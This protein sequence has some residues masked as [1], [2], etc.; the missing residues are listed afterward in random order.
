ML[1]KGGACGGSQGRPIDVLQVHERRHLLDHGGVCIVLEVQVLGQHSAR[2]EPLAHWGAVAEWGSVEPTEVGALLV[3]SAI[4]CAQNKLRTE[5]SF[6]PQAGLGSWSPGAPLTNVAHPGSGP[7]T[8]SMEKAVGLPELHSGGSP[9][10][11]RPAALLPFVTPLTH[12]SIREPPGGG[13]GY[14]WSSEAHSATGRQG[15][16]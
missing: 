14:T 13:Q 10:D 1:F 3:P 12:R 16:G 9:G 5:G 11:V 8:L 6:P 7:L 15:R 2:V 4:S